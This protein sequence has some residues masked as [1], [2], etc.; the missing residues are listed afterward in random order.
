MKERSNTPNFASMDTQAFV[1]GSGSVSLNARSPA[2]PKPDVRTTLTRGPAGKRSSGGRLRRWSCRRRGSS[3]ERPCRCPE[4]R[5]DELST[6]AIRSAQS[7]GKRSNGSVKLPHQT[8]SRVS[9]WRGRVTRVS[10]LVVVCRAGAG[11]GRG[12]RLSSSRSH[13]RGRRRGRRTGAAR[14]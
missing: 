3:G 2:M 4:K 9:R 13:S 10:V 14:R 5:P 12:R 7:A 6:T 11:R 8:R 1:Q